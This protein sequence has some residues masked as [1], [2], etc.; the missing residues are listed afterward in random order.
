ML[1]EKRVSESGK[2]GQRDDLHGEDEIASS[3][4]R[5]GGDHNYYRS[6]PERYPHTSPDGYA[7]YS[8]HRYHRSLSRNFLSSASG[9][10]KVMKGVTLIH[11][12]GVAGV[13]LRI[14]IHLRGKVSQGGIHHPEGTHTHLKGI[15]SDTVHQDMVNMVKIIATLIE[16]IGLQPIG[17]TVDISLRGLRRGLVVRHRNGKYPR[18]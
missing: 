14:N 2:K 3:W 10:W 7:R 11:L 9:H 1:A 5:S 16:V 17:M 13:R 4:Y 18:I 8:P 15:E 6:S 12:Q